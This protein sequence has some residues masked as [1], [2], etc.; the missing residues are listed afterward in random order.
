MNK[1]R[2]CAERF[3]E[4]Y[5]QRITKASRIVE[6]EVI[7]ANVGANGFTTLRQ[8][9]LLAKNLG[10]SAGHHLLDIGS[11]RGWPAIYLAKETGCLA[12]L[13]DLPIPALN[14]ALKRA[15]TQEVSQRVS[16][17]RASATHL[18]FADRSF[19]AVSHTDTL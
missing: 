6:R 3:R 16:I 17:V 15:H 12:T 1:R 7:G 8:A 19:D 9:G 5:S 10:L 14:S 4:R 2:D 18:P 11:G 13:T